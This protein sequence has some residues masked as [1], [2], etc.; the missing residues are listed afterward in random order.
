[1]DK[2]CDYIKGLLGTVTVSTIHQRLRD[3]QKLQVS[4][5]SFR[6]WVHATLPHEAA[7]SQFTVLREDVAPGEEAQIDYG[8]LGQWTDPRTG[9]RHRVWVFVM[10]LLCSRH[11]RD[12]W[13]APAGSLPVEVP[14][15]ASGAATGVR[16][17]APVVL[18]I[19]FPLA[20]SLSL[21]PA[22][23]FTL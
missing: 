6:R 14:W 13:G 22:A 16:V 1:M 12:R 18:W 21:E 9:K 8:F 20:A 19:Y 5:S 17:T 3:E 4:I 23:T 7:K 11:G 15:T 10:V 2:H